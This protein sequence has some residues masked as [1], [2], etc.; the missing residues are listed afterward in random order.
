MIYDEV[1]QLGATAQKHGSATVTFQWYPT[2]KEFTSTDFVQID[3]FDDF[4][5][6]LPTGQA[7]LAGSS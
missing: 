1:H 5:T 6:L 3:V 4:V 2:R 7:L